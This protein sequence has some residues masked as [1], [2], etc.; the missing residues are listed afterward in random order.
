MPIEST[1]RHARLATML[2]FFISGATYATWGIHVPTIQ[3]RFGLNEALLSLAM[4]AV[5][6]GAI[7]AMSH[8]GRWISRHGSHR[9]A[10][11]S[12]LALGLALALILPAPSYPLLVVALLL[13]GITNAAFDVAMNTQAV[14]VEKAWGR[15]IMSS[16]HGMFSLGGMAG[17]AGGGA[18]LAAGLTPLQHCSAM[19]ILVILS[20]L[21]VSRSLLPDNQE[22]TPQAG[23]TPHARR[24]SGHAVW[25]LGA[26]AFLGLVAEGGL[27]DWSVIYLRDAAGAS[28]ATSSLAYAAFSAGM[29]AGRFAGDWLRARHGEVTLLRCSAALA[30]AGM[31]LALIWPST[32][33]FGFTLVGLGG[34][35]LIP[36]LFAAAARIPGTAPAAGIAGVAR[37]AYIGLLLGPVLIGGLA[38]AS[39]LR[40]GLGLVALCIAVIGV[41]AHRALRATEP[42]SRE[43]TTAGS[44]GDPG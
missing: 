42:Q 11:G 35:N 37:L 30:F 32:A 4:F 23:E 10:L 33:L 12:A 31:L 38:Q 3:Q 2:L 25:A 44:R 18:L 16:L 17:A 27:Y 28:V 40:I 36:V 22:Q 14:A 13:F 15:P 34:A 5:A 1:P 9:A 26:L 29:A 19:A 8:V 43:I 39:N 6:G 20:G 41:S 24:T 7:A 21:L